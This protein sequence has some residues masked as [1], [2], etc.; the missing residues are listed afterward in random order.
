MPTY[1][2][3]RDIPDTFTRADYDA[4]AL[5]SIALIDLYDR[6][7]QTLGHR[8]AS[9]EALT[10][11]LTPPRGWAAG[12][13]VDRDQPVN[14]R[15]R[16]IRSYWAPGTTWGVCLYEAPSASSLEEFQLTCAVDQGVST[17][18]VTEIRD[19]TNTDD[20]GDT[21]ET[22]EGW[23][24]AAMEVPIPEESHAA[25]A[26]TD[27]AGQA[28]LSADEAARWIRAYVAVNE[29]DAS[30]PLALFAAPAPVVSAVARESR[31]YRIVE[32][33]PD[34]YR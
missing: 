27:A 17:W 16:W 15:V 26:M 11:E 22:P 14:W 5:E 19:A 6:F 28:P 8:P 20:A 10:S 12:D 34:D 24:L 13:A 9:R 29:E 3:L 23:E 2:I 1:A 18:E 33:R 32:I 21:S 4:V 25:A 31:A 30:A 7:C